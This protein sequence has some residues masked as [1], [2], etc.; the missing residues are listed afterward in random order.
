LKK[1]PTWIIPNDETYTIPLNENESFLGIKGES[2]NITPDY[3]K[4]S[5]YQ[6]TTSLS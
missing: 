4:N 6:R 2:K 3:M 5:Y 1:L